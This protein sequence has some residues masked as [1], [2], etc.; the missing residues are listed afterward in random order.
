MKNKY[1]KLIHPGG[2]RGFLL[3]KPKRRKQDKKFKSAE[4]YAVVFFP[5]ITGLGEASARW[6]NTISTIS[7]SRKAAIVKFMDGITAGET[8]ETYYDA[9]Y[10]VRKI[11]ITDLGDAL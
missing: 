5:K 4:F 9:G 3:E 6:P 7:N 11:N 1:Y 10:R 2:P 8:W